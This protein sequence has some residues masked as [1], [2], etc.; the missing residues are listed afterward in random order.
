MK[1]NLNKHFSKKLFQAHANMVFNQ[2]N[3]KLMNKVNEIKIK[4]LINE[5]QERHDEIKGMLHGVKIKNRNTNRNTNSKSI[6]YNV[7]NKTRKNIKKIN[8]SSLNSYD[9]IND[10]YRNHYD[11]K[12]KRKVYNIYRQNNPTTSSLKS[13]QEVYIDLEKLIIKLKQL[14]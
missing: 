13:L 10:F 3:K 1:N 8:I 7:F 12:I 2:S 9:K 11:E 14:I 4:K 6:E 5:L